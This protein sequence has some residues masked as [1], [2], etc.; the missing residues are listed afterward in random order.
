MVEL[1]LPKNFCITEFLLKARGSI[2]L[3]ASEDFHFLPEISVSQV[4]RK[5]EIKAY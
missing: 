2:R 1:F 3:D 4:D 5:T